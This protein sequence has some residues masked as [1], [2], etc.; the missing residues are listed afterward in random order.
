MQKGMPS[1]RS[2]R[3]LVVVAAA[4]V[5]VL[6]PAT[7]RADDSAA[8]TVVGQ[9]VQTWAEDAA[10]EHPADEG[11]EGPLTWVETD[12][13]AVRVPTEELAG[14]PVGATV[15]VTVG[16]AVPDPDTEQGIDDA[17]R[18]LDADVVRRPTEPV[19]PVRA[20]TNEVTVAL[21]APEGA[22]RD[23]TTVRQVVEAVDGSVADFWAEQSA[24]ALSIGVTAAHD[25]IATRAGCSDPT[26]LWDE[27]AR[28]VGFRPGP[29]RHLLLYVS[30]AAEDC[31]YAL[32]EVGAA[33]ASG[34]RLYVRD[35]VPTVIAHEF[36][37]NFGLGHS[38]GRQCD[39]GVETGSCRTKPYRDFYDVM[40]V[41]WDHVGSLNAA[42]AARLGLLPAA[43]QQR[44]TT[45]GGTTGVSL[46][47]LAGGTGTRVLGLTD[48]DGGTW[49]LEYRA[50]TGRDAWLE[51]DGN[52][53]GLEAGVLLHRAGDLPDTSLLLDGTPSVAAAWDTD[54]QAALPVGVPVAIA[55]GAFT[56]TV[57]GVTP[58]AATVRV[59]PDTTVSDVPAPQAGPGAPGDL[60]EAQPCA[61]CAVAPT[62]P[63]AGT[64]EPSPAPLAAAPSADPGPAAGTAAAE[65]Q[66][67]GVPVPRSGTA[68]AVAAPMAGAALAG[69]MLLLVRRL[70]RNATAAA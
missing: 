51:S 15:E 62:G 25:W 52:R 9:V 19:L 2:L 38:S 12:D 64:A 13:G 5:P 3:R 18:V 23:D 69:S 67:A 42:Q 35:T 44:L 10:G 24:G 39:G 70:R 26:A 28:S 31:S 1:A 43:A 4:A 34:G 46:A 14:V 22:A 63:E 56:V 20:L 60:L 29:G 36:G 49:W 32:A 58:E 66:A 54:L 55:G 68:H 11:T 65:E 27:T 45:A 57:D 33:P 41:S 59:V 16:S 48:G 53:Y 50:A 8:T 40:G 7:A 17:R 21:V 6:L 61:D 37:H 47:P 30:R